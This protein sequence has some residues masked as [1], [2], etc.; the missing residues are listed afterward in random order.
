MTKKNI[1]SEDS[2]LFRQAIGTVNKLKKDDLILSPKNKPKPYPQKNTAQTKNSFN[3][4]LEFETEKLYQEDS[5]NFLAPGLQKNILKKLRKGFF[6]ID[7]SIDLHG[8]TS[9]EAQHQLSQF[10]HRCIESGFRCVHIIHGKGYGS[11]N[12]HPVLKNN[13]NLWLRQ[14]SE[15]QAFCSTPVKHGGTGAAFVLLRHSKSPEFT[16]K[17]NKEEGP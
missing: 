7:S 1:S 4:S 14:H 11:D 6:G 15:I 8:L 16:E 5:F 3:Q 2:A 17:H 12:N 9:Q 10:L 13:V